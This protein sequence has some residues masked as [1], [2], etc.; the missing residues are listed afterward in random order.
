MTSDKSKIDEFLTWINKE[1]DEAKARRDAARSAENIATLAADEADTAYQRTLAAQNAMVALAELASDPFGM[2]H[3]H[4][5]KGESPADRHGGLLRLLSE[6]PAEIT[7]PELGG[8]G[9]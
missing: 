3:L 9:G 2:K 7:K 1:V 4:E 5:F 8:E 6:S